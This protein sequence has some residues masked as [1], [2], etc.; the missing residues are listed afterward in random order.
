M[1][2]ENVCTIKEEGKNNEMFN[3]EWIMN[4]SDKVMHKKIDF[5]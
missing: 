5:I 4:V 3:I 2:Y 1:Y